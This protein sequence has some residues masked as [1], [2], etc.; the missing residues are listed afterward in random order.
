MYQYEV[1]PFCCKLKA[2]LDYHK[3]SPSSFVIII[4]C[5]WASRVGCHWCLVHQFIYHL[6]CV[7][8]QHGC[9]CCMVLWPMLRL[10]DSH[11]CPMALGYGCSL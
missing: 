6:V 10:L 4:K 8:Y 7:I 11:A 5:V 3:V 9:E 1:C 2:F